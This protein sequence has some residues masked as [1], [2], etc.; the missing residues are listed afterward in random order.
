MVAAA[1]RSG[2]YTSRHGWHYTVAPPVNERSL[3][4]WPIQTLGADIL[5]CAVIFADTLGIEMLA[6]AHDAVLIEADEDDIRAK[7]GEMDF[8]MRLAAMLLTGGFA[9]GVD[10][11]DSAIKR[12]GERFLEERGKR[13]FAVAER[14]VTSGAAHHAA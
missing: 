5:R 6:T 3:R 1:V 11:K 8:C 4:N 14:F 9:L 13:T 2:G 12:H 10:V 7:V